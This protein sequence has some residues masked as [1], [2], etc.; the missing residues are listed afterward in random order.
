MTDAWQPQDPDPSL[1]PVPPIIP[2]PYGPPQAAAS[3]FGQPDSTASRFGIAEYERPSQYAQPSQY[4]QQDFGQQQF[5]QQ[6][7]QLAYGQAPAYGAPQWVARPELANWGLRVAA[8]I[9]D[10]LVT[11]LPWLVCVAYTLGTASYGVD[12]L[13]KG[14]VDPTTAGF[15]VLAVGYLASLGAWIW[16]R[17]V[18]QGRTGQSIG[19][20]A[21]HL[22]LVA[23][24]TGEP[25][26]AGLAFGREFAHILDG[27]CY[28]GYLWPL[29]DAKNQTFADKICGT[30]V[31]RA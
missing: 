25:A 15:A 22:R 7:G 16:N 4:G 28:L 2:S 26:G 11:S 27:F 19:K 14:T 5:G 13:G 6:P 9:V 1:R 23:E 3:R 8:S 20:S 31:T 24:Y 21:L 10:S 17:V 30:L 12:A 29:W 18:R